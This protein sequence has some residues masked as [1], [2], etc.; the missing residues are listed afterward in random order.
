MDPKINDQIL[1]W[2][3]RKYGTYGAVKATRGHFHDYLGMTFD[4]SHEGKVII[5]M[6]DYV[7]NMIKDLLMELGPK[8][9]DPTPAQDN[10]FTTGDPNT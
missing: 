8:D 9:T 2:L 3:N 1:E 7:A 10:L 6:R 5:D 4:F